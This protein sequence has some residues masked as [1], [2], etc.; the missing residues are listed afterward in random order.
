MHPTS[1]FR[2]IFAIAENPIAQ[3]N[4]VI[5]IVGEKR[6]E[7]SATV[8]IATTVQAIKTWRKTQT[9]NQ[10]RSL[11]WSDLFIFFI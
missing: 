4:I 1:H 5:V 10:R 6:V 3:R 9:Q 7:T 11:N 8:Q 2:M